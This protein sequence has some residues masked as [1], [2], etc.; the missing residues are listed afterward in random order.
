[1]K[2]NFPFWATKQKLGVFSVICPH[3]FAVCPSEVQLGSVKHCGV[4]K[5][6]GLQ[7]LAGCLAVSD[8]AETVGLQARLLSSFTGLGASVA[9]GKQ[10]HWVHLA[11]LIDRLWVGRWHDAWACPGHICGPVIRA[12]FLSLSP[13]NSDG[14]VA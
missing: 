9:R 13:A 6:S 11:V 8:T 5:F 1:M 7:E 4:Q 14:C 10:Q 2:Q 12:L 3:T